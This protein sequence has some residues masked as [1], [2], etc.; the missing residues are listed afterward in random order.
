MPTKTRRQA[1]RRGQREKGTTDP[2]EEGGDSG[3]AGRGKKTRPNGTTPE[4][5]EK[6][7]VENASMDGEGG[8]DVQ[9][10]V[11]D[12]AANLEREGY[13][14]DNAAKN[15]FGSGEEGK[16]EEKEEDTNAVGGGAAGGK[17]QP[18]KSRASAWTP[19]AASSSGKGT[20]S[21]GKKSGDGSGKSGGRTSFAPGMKFPRKL[22]PGGMERKRPKQAEGASG[23]DGEEEE[24]VLVRPNKCVVK[25]L[26]RV[27][28]TKSVGGAIRAL[29]GNALAV[30]QER[31][32]SAVWVCDL[33]GSY[34]SKVGELPE[35][36]QDILDDWGFWNEAPKAFYPTIR[37]GKSRWIG[38]GRMIMACSWDCKDL[39]KKVSIKMAEIAAQDESGNT[40]RLEYA[41]NQA[42]KVG[43][44]NILFGV[45]GKQHNVS[46]TKRDVVALLERCRE[47]APRLYPDRY[48]RAVYGAKLGDIELDRN[49][50]ANT[51]WENPEH[52]KRLK[53]KDKIP[54]WAKQALLV[55]VAL[56]KEEVVK[57]LLGY[58][59]KKGYFTRLFGNFAWHSF[60]PGWDCEEYESG[61]LGL[62][63]ERHTAIMRSMGSVT[64][65]GFLKL[66]D[67]LPFDRED[68]EDG[69]PRPLIYK[70]ARGI[71]MN[72]RCGE[73]NLRLFTY[74]GMG[75]G[76][77]YE[78]FFT[79]GKGTPEHRERAGEIARCPAAFCVYYLLKRGV[80]IHCI[81]ILLR[82]S[83]TLAARQ[84]AEEAKYVNGK[85]WTADQLARQSKF[86]K[87][88]K[89]GIFDM[90]LG[91]GA[92]KLL[93]AQAE[94]AAQEA[95]L[96]GAQVN[97]KDTTAFNFKEDLSVG[98]AARAARGDAST[99]YS[100]AETATFGGT[101]Y[102]PAEEDSI[103][104]TESAF[105][106]GEKEEEEF[107][108]FNAE[109]QGG[110]AGGKAAS[111][112]ATSTKVHIEGMENVAG[113]GAGAE[114]EEPME[115]GEEEKAG[116]P[117]EF[118]RGMSAEDIATQQQRMAEEAVRNA[119]E[120]QGFHDTQ[121]GVPPSGQ[122]GAEQSANGNNVDDTH[123]G[124]RQTAPSGP[125][126]Q[127]AEGAAPNQTAG[128]GDGARADAAIG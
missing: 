65:R 94:E 55:V 25:V 122:E 4:K 10:E 117:A 30:L 106:D 128:Q 87:M 24:P 57:G 103:E 66:D 29:L 115:G 33:D 26:L 76:G 77:V 64:L 9:D 112:A 101:K 97:P 105:W 116:G 8:D 54:A 118:F 111:T 56:D 88:D 75:K 5:A 41:D 51:P 13:G 72:M 22:T 110:E 71:F 15:L 95:G 45:P 79:D 96:S 70:T 39:L 36:F 73:H 32:E 109:K 80:K 2:S 100:K 121:S 42:L 67:E 61:D 52:S 114:E 7:E 19:K 78:A 12:V 47:E 48:P 123:G 81:E 34:A 124:A 43:N 38:G 35:D 60:N 91:M 20:N 126:G 16:E 86:A 62:E 6:P 90:K 63:V 40:I 14:K 69:N 104:S 82:K 125:D 11:D 50:V 46:G 85:M 28:K 89:L 84:E 127:A 21:G 120:F 59:E 83:C 18:P 113:G 27:A 92:T 107:E 102:E 31:D 108:E 98:R 68:D 119:G 53:D 3:D 58:A 99:A 74:I 1:G 93:E 44:R 23:G 37:E 17:K 49:F